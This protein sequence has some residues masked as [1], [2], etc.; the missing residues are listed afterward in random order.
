MQNLKYTIQVNE[1]DA[2]LVKKPYY[3]YPNEETIYYTDSAGQFQLSHDQTA[4]FEGIKGESKVVV[5]E[6]KADPYDPERLDQMYDVDY[7]ATDANGQP[8]PSESSNAYI[9]MPA[10]GSASVVV[11]NSAKFTKPL[12]VTKT[13]T[14]NGEEN[15]PMPKG[16]DA[17]FQLYQLAADGTTWN[18][19]GD[20]IPYSK[21]TAGSYTYMLEEGQTYA[22]T[23][24]VNNEG[25]T[26]DRVEYLT[27]NVTTVD[28]DTPKATKPDGISGMVEM[29]MKAGAN[30]VGDT[31]AFENV[32]GILYGDISIDKNV[33]V[34]GTADNT[35]AGTFNFAVEVNSGGSPVSGTFD[36]VYEHANSDL[37]ATV[38]LNSSGEGTLQIPAGSTVTIMMLPIGAT[39]TV[40]E[41]GYD[42]YAPSWNTSENSA[43]NHG[44]IAQGEVKVNPMIIHFTNTTGA[45]LPSTGGIGTHHFTTLGIA[46]MLGAGVLLLDQR[47]R[48]GGPSA[49]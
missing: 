33:V 30:P 25:K 47:R 32:Y 28:E 49:T 5:K 11:T 45:V 16:F 10:A 31:I 26:A 18:K 22:V 12:K 13:F 1:N 37:P 48:K 27:T 19:V 21:F 20:P 34:N 35:G 38:K 39:V 36:L 24:V 9:E 42:G 8:V 43:V 44:S 2:P 6:I 23:E 7:T 46:M 14:I 4:V 41:T 3:I 29:G 15:A 40:E 17:D